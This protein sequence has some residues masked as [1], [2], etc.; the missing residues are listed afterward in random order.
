MT[1]V[2]NELILKDL[3]FVHL[4][5]SLLFKCCNL[6][7]DVTC[8]DVLNLF[9]K[10]SLVEIAEEELMEIQSHGSLG[11]VYH[12]LVDG[13]LCLDVGSSGAPRH[14]AFAELF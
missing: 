8:Q 7:S 13:L 4:E 2:L 9:H 12:H 14:I 6:S 11:Y 3:K 1:K 5:Q 10:L